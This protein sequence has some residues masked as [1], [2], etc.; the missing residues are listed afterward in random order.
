MNQTSSCVPIV[1]QCPAA[2]YSFVLNQRIISN[3]VIRL[4]YQDNSIAPASSVP[5]PVRTAAVPPK[6]RIFPWW[7]WNKHATRVHDS[8]LS[9]ADDLVVYRDQVLNLKSVASLSSTFCILS[10]PECTLVFSFCDSYITKRQSCE[11]T[12]QIKTWII[13]TWLCK[14][15]QMSPYSSVV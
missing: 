11:F 12:A 7:K 2:D 5:K 1:S 6:E 3:L 8:E 15:R 14:A 10:V 4:C 9:L 13:G